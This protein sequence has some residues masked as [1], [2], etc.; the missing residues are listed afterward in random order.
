MMQAKNQLGGSNLLSRKRLCTGVI[1]DGPSDPPIL[2]L[3]AAAGVFAVSCAPDA[4]L[5]DTLT[6]TALDYA[7]LAPDSVPAGPAI[8]A[9]INQG[10]VRHELYFVRLRAGRTLAE[11][12][13]ATTAQERRALTDQ[14]GAILVAE[15]GQSSS[16]RLL[17]DLTSGRTYRLAVFLARHDQRTASYHSSHVEGRL[18]GV[19]T[20]WAQRLLWRRLTSAAA[21]G[22]RRPR[23]AAELITVAAASGRS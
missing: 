3:A 14:S 2:G 9:F 18:R 16:T 7:F 8:V 10:S 23:L 21:G 5:P 6:V 11:F 13:R 20:S 22:P 19:R 17:V 1:H 15:P 4:Q 12:S